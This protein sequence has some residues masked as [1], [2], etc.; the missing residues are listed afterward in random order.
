MKKSIYLLVIALLLVSCWNNENV[1]WIQGKNKN[2]ENQ[3]DSLRI[4]PIKINKE[5]IKSQQLKYNES[6]EKLYIWNSV[7]ISSSLPTNFPKKI[8]IYWENKTYINSNV[9]D[10]IFFISKSG[11]DIRK[12]SLF[13]KSLFNKLWY[14]SIINNTLDDNLEKPTIENLEFVLNNPKYKELKE[15]ELPNEEKKYLDR[16]FININSNIPENIEKWM[17][18]KWIFVEIYYNQINY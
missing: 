14:K 11:E 8:K 6:E 13:Y 10:Y 2:L 17:W 9:T 15:W 18:L 7:E 16:I 5:D 12:I 4:E 3:N 1:E